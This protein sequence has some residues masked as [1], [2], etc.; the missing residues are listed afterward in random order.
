MKNEDVVIEMVTVI[1]ERIVVVTD[2]VVTDVEGEY[3][4]VDPVA[5]L[6][7]HLPCEDAS[8]HHFLVTR[9]Q[10]VSNAHIKESQPYS[11]Y[12]ACNQ[13]KFSYA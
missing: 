4:V 5:L 3:D 6:N 13:R 7:L 12:L 8:K 10:Y 9:N 11:P 1:K 2:A